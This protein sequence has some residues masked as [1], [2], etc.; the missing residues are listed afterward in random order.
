VIDRLARVLAAALPEYVGEDLA[1]ALWLAARYDQPAKPAAPQLTPVEPPSRSTDPDD[2]PHPPIIDDDP[3]AVTELAL[4]DD[5]PKPEPTPTVPATEVG[6]DV[7]VVARPTPATATAL[8]LFRRVRRPGPPTVDVDGTV[9]ATADARRL[10]VVTRPARERGL[11]V[12]LVVDQTPVATVWAEAIADLEATLRRTGAF[13]AVT[14][15]SLDTANRS[16]DELV[17]R[18][19]AGAAH[20]TDF[21]IDPS[22]RRLVLVLT[23]SSA[24]RWHS[25]PIWQALARWART[26]PTALLHLLPRSYWGY[27]ATGRPTAVARSRRPAHPNSTLEVATV[28]WSDHESRAG[29]PLPVLAMRSDDI[30][31]W[32]RAV[33]AGNTWTDAVWARLPEPLAVPPPG[34]PLTIADRVHAFQT[35]ASDGAQDLARILAGAKLLSLPLI[36]VLHEQL[37]PAPEVEQLAEVLVSGLLEELPSNDA[38]PGLL[39]F[40]PDAVDLLFQGTT[41]SQ[42]WSV[43]EVLTRYLEHHVGSG[44]AVSA[45]F[46]DPH[47]NAA[48]NGDLIPFAALGRE[49]AGRLGI[50]LPEVGAKKDEHPRQ[51]PSRSE[52]RSGVVPKSRGGSGILCI[53]GIVPAEPAEITAAE[54]TSALIDGLRGSGDHGNADMLSDHSVPLA[55]Y[56][57][58][59]ADATALPQDTQSQEFE[60]TLLL[61]WLAN[62]PRTKEHQEL[63]EFSRTSPWPEVRQNVANVLN[64]LH[65]VPAPLT[66]A[67]G[68]WR[69]LTDPATRAAVQERVARLVT[70]D[71]RMIVAHSFGAVVAYEALRAHPEWPVHTLITV[72]SPL[73]SP[74]VFERLDVIGPSADQW[75]GGIESWTDIVSRGDVVGAGQNLRSLVGGAVEMHVVAHGR[76]SHTAERYLASPVT[77]SAVSAALWRTQDRA[78][79][80][81]L[82]YAPGGHQARTVGILQRMGYEHVPL[83]WSAVLAELRDF[84]HAQ[85]RRPD[86]VVVLDLSGTAVSTAE[87]DQAAGVLASSIVRRSLILVDTSTLPTN[88][89]LSVD[90]LVR[91]INQ[92]VLSGDDRRTGWDD[93]GLTADDVSALFPE[94]EL[95]PRSSAGTRAADRDVAPASAYTVSRRRVV[96]RISAWL[97]NATDHRPL[98]LTGDPR[99]ARTTLLSYLTDASD[100]AS[101]RSTLSGD[102]QSLW[103]H[104]TSVALVSAGQRSTEEVLHQL[105]E[106]FFLDLVDMD[107]ERGIHA[108]LTEAGS[109]HH[110]P[111]VFLDG[112]DEA[113]DPD[114]LITTLLLP[115]IQEGQGTPRFL[116]ATRRHLVTQ[117]RAGGDIHLID[118]DH[119]EYV[120]TTHQTICAV[121]I[122]GYGGMNRTRANYV[123]L[124]TGMYESVTTA[125]AEAG[126]PWDACVKEDVGDSILVLAPPTIPKGAFVGPLPQAL[127]K[128]LDSHNATHIPEER[129][130][131]RLSL[132]AGEITFDNY[133]IAGAPIIH[134]ARLLDAPP[135][136][137]A[138]ASSPGSLAMIVSDW[139]YT[140]V[141]RHSADH[142]PNEYRRVSVSVKETTGTGWIRLPGHAVPVPVASP[143]TTTRALRSTLRPSSPEF[144]DIVNALEEIPCMR[145]EPTRAIV[146]D[147]LRFAG[148]IRYFPTRRA[149]ITSILRTCLDLEG[150]LA[151]LLNVIASMEPTG[152]IPIRRLGSLLVDDT[153]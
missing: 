69:Y 120:G 149:H 62:G 83:T 88:R 60:R 57:E 147:Q 73:G 51:T 150:G 54:W 64:E 30:V 19:V 56:P 93:S 47:G 58:L 49:L 103:P 87:L 53:P 71:T 106:A 33:V 66:Y 122:A 153:A 126:I 34:A 22:G 79:R 32:S 20:G 127:T 129:V 27:T 63:I 107:V 40:R 109:G 131:L 100:S 37:V 9:E 105:L 59:L 50:E 38:P 72:G 135:L 98:V 28:W 104:G 101:R 136:K 11:D 91:R 31:G 68:M 116:L 140:D 39:R 146:I 96:E 142:E 85:D 61:Q 13:R 152:S 90:D 43:F 132:H 42:E 99:S 118:L 36:R 12:V 130:K 111:A 92:D 134:A 115:L 121:D 6:L 70:D 143:T 77:G 46:A 113:Q 141:V 110:L 23:D 44:D 16:A 35:R 102:D 114:Q 97:A 108:I 17:L 52:N 86:D 26:M 2:D 125:F 74:A 119:R 139:F 7:P 128:A 137:E 124:R 84:A 4:A 148:M 133:G 89:I 10:V 8:S 1:D 21:I 151:E 67:T 3:D 14:R 123:A 138:L 5:E 29:V 45:M 95:A 80:Y 82:T 65:G 144:Y 25:R 117:L 18:D 76:G 48:A 15:W 78:R 55:S 24:Q 81:V 112:I 94:A 145:N 75:P 41:T